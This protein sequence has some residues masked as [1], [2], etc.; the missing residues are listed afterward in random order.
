MGTW[1]TAPRSSGGAAARAQ[2]CPAALPLVPFLYQI[3]AFH[4]PH[5][6]FSAPDMHIFCT[7]TRIHQHL[8]Q[9][10][11][12]TRVNQCLRLF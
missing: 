2:P 1:S 7:R 11:T 4:V 3:Y 10:S 5:L 8:N 12:M 6:S 9:V